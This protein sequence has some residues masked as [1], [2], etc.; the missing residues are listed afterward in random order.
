MA[1]TKR[2]DRIGETSANAYGTVAKI[3]EYD[4]GTNM[5]VEF[6]NGYKKTMSYKEFNNGS[7]KSPYCKTVCGVGFKGEGEYKVSENSIHTKQYKLWKAILTRCYNKSNTDRY[8][9]YLD[10]T[11]CNEWHNFQNFAKWYDENYYEIPDQ[12]MCIDK[13]IL[14]KGNKTYSQHTCI[15]VPQCINKLFTTTKKKRGD[16][17]I[18]VSYHKRDKVYEANCNRGAKKEQI[19]LGRFQNKEDAFTA[20][21]EYKELQIFEVAEQYKDLIPSTLYDAMLSWK[22]EIDD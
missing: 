19:Y 11:V 9:A 12:Q 10:S 22:I 7:F 17:P 4:T 6:D 21:K 13:D 18:G 16:N 8:G 3:I 2:A 5:T 15:F 14:I 1:N 20:Y